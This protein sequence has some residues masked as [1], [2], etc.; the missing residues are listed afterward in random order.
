MSEAVN[1]EP[2]TRIYLLIYNLRTYLYELATYGSEASLQAG[3]VQ[4][5]PGPRIEVRGPDAVRRGL[6]LGRGAVPI[7]LT[8]GAGGRRLL[9]EEENPSGTY[10]NAYI[11]TNRTVLNVSL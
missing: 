4:V 7:T 1:C 5:R 8:H 11:E 6:R 3:L 2:W 9:T 10:I